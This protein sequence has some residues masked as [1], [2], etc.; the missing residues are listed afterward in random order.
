[1]NLTEQSRENIEYMINE[2][3]KKLQVVN[4]G[5]M[6]AESFD[7]DAYEDLKDIYEMVM[8]KS[9]FSVS[10]MDAIVSELGRLRK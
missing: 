9:S 6:K 2:I 4:A 8:S 10:E 5:A 3:I 1:M 7:T